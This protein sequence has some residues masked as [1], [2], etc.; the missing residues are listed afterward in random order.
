MRG[1]RNPEGD[2]V[3]AEDRGPPGAARPSLGR[4][5]KLCPRDSGA[6]GRTSH[7]FRVSTLEGP[8][9]RTQIPLRGNESECGISHG[10]RAEMGVIGSE[11]HVRHKPDRGAAHRGTRPTESSHRSSSRRAEEERTPTKEPARSQPTEARTE[12]DVKGSAA[13]PIPEDEEVLG[14]AE[15]SERQKLSQVG[16]PSFTV[17]AWPIICLLK[18][19][20]AI[21]I[22]TDRTEVQPNGS[23]P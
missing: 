9:P 21:G 10:G 16:C 22:M 3:E 6:E 19:K 18:P 15:E 11:S 14:R 23:I 7:P 13:G 8:R 2:R 12:V 1:S 20:K 5:A 4:Q 17:L